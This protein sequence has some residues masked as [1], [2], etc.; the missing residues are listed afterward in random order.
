MLKQTRLI[1][2]GEYKQQ[3][4]NAKKF[5]RGKDISSN[6]LPTTHYNGSL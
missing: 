3:R 5:A 6:N 2:A 1:Y 4:V